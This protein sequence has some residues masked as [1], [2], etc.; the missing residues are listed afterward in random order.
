MRVL[1]IVNIGYVIPYFFGDQFSYLSKKNIKSYVACIDD[2]D[3]N[4][5]IKK[6]NLNFLK[7]PIRRSIS[8]IDDIR[9]VIILC[10]FIKKEKI[11]L[12]IGHTPKGGLI[13]V[14]TG[15][16]LRKKSIYVR[17]G[18]V[19]ETSNGLKRLILILCEK[20]NSYFS[21]KTICVSP[22]VRD[23]SEKMNL[24]TPNKNLL[25]NKGTFNGVDTL[26]KFNPSYLIESSL[27]PKN[28]RF[29][30]IGRFANDKGIVEL[31]DAWKEIYEIGLN[32]ELVF[33]GYLDDRDPIPNDYNDFILSNEN[34]IKYLGKIKD[35]IQ[36]YNKIDVLVLPSYR[37]GFPTVVLEASSMKKAV[38]TTRSTGCVDS[39]LNLETG[40][41]C[42]I[43]PNSIK[44]AMEF[45]INHPKKI[46]EFGANGR[47]FVKNNFEQTIV[48]NNWSKIIKNLN[49]E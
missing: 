21:D 27:N 10:N 20:F 29:G 48:W 19:H 2:E 9:C 36:F 46:N 30:F 28:I 22:S 42:D 24:S 31:I 6:Y 12:I 33:A 23:L 47:S 18:L 1:N 14:L 5:Y 16:I 3:F 15:L 37:E 4:Y 32:H 25:L 26:K 13:S 38:I 45:Y 35:S 39:I 43:N 8:I 41:F 17:H 49:Y 7:I 44:S 40:I 34:N 11:D